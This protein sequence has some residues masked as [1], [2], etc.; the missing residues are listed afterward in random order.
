[1]KSNQDYQFPWEREER[2]SAGASGR[3]G[4]PARWLFC[5]LCVAVA[6]TVLA[7]YVVTYTVE[8]N[9]YTGVIQGQN[10]KI[11]RLSAEA[12]KEPVVITDS[13][14][15]ELDFLKM[16][17]DRYAYYADERTDEEKMRDVLRAYIEA[18][19]DEYA[20]YLTEEEYRVSMED[21][22]GGF[23][24]IGVSGGLAS[25]TVDDT[26]YYVFQVRAVY[27][28]SSAEGAGIVAGDLIYAV[29]TDGEYRTLEYFETL[30][31][32][33]NAIRGEE[34]TTVEI[35]LFHPSGEEYDSVHYAL[36]RKPVETVNVYY[37]LSEADPTVGIIRITQFLLNTPTQFKE[38]VLALR[39]AGAEHFVIDL[40]ENPGGALPSIRSVL[41]YFLQEGDLILSAV[42]RDGNVA[43]SILAKKMI[44][45]GD[46]E[47]CS[48]AQEEIGMFADLDIAVLCDENTASAAEVFTA[49]VEDYHLGTVFGKTTY[50]KGIMQQTL[51]LADL[52]GGTFDGYLK[53][54]T[55]AYA[56]K[57][58]ESYHGI[59]VV[60]D[61]EVSLNE[62]A[63]KIPVSL[64]NEADD[65]QL[66]AAIASFA[67]ES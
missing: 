60:P 47:G 23:C 26:F 19:G 3:K 22:S 5:L 45:S 63:A 11:S 39:D 61:V 29:L 32:V 50:G 65:D 12:A 4:I 25:V 56:T 16:I 8:R 27:P 67:S 58:G 15:G 57:R 37:G 53:L 64:R 40:R 41:T 9:Y 46:G 35:R 10:E 31:G 1:M 13:E 59:G 21:R 33:Q 34:G 17:V 42:D 6:L 54:T 49:T 36:I 51:S 7:T 30:A 14:F 38:A 2:A 55:F 18:T 43:D 62:D 28:N 44:Y 52:S 24:G 48:V 66:L 20:E